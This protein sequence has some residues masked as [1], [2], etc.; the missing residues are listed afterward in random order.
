M[1][2]PEVPGLRGLLA[3]LRALPSSLGA[4]HERG[5]WERSG[6]PTTATGLAARPMTV[7]VRLNTQP[8]GK[9]T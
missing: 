4:T 6:A 8:P 1:Q 7:I 5:V 2:R 3:S 9:Q